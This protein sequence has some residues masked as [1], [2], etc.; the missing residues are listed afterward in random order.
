MLRVGAYEFDLSREIGKGA[1]GSVFKGKEVETSEIVAGKRITVEKEHLHNFEK[2]E[3]LL[4]ELPPHENVRVLIPHIRTRVLSNHRE[5][6]ALRHKV[7]NLG[8]GETICLYYNLF[9]LL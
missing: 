8:S 6:G 2:E 7:W 5:Q 1:F 9:D 4:L 3:K